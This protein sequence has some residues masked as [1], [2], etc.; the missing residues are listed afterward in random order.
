MHR[1]QIVTLCGKFGIRYHRKENNSVILKDKNSKKITYF[2]YGYNKP[3][4]IVM[5]SYIYKGFAI[6][7]DLRQIGKTKSWPL[8]GKIF[9]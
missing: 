5:D 7:L 3:K 6:K 2:P 9:L 1:C 8:L 4:Y